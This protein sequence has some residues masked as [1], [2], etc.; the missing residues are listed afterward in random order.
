MNQ[1]ERI[2]AV[3][4]G[5]WQPRSQEDRLLA[6]SEF[7]LP[8]QDVRPEMAG[9]LRDLPMDE[10]PLPPPKSGDQLSPYFCDNDDPEK[11]IKQGMEV[12]YIKDI[13]C[14]NPS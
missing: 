11:Y 4:G 10:P 12:L 6:E 7:K 1:L 3:Q 8:L 9:I 14:G 5:N 13:L 2:V